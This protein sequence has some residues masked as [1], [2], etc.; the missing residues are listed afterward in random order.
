MTKLKPP[1]TLLLLQIASKLD[2]LCERVEKLEN[3]NSS[4][5]AAIWG[6]KGDV[7][8]I[9]YYLTGEDEVTLQ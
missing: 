3:S 8:S 4:N 7:E 6:L 2:D 1:D 9:Y 5:C